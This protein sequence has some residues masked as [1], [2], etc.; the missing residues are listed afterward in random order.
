MTKNNILKILVTLPTIYLTPSHAMMTDDYEAL[1]TK[2]PILRQSHKT[3]IFA[4]GHD[5]GQEASIQRNGEGTSS[6]NA[7]D[8]VKKRES[9]KQEGE[10]MEQNKRLS[11]SA[12]ALQESLRKQGLTDCRVVEFSES[13][14]TALDAAAVIGCDVAQIVKVFPL[15]L[16]Q[17]ILYHRLL[18]LFFL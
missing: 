9:Q 11:K 15:S 10:E 18:I 8:V 4:N 14:R 6:I 5:E 3:S 17:L 1:E 12:Q 7:L 2:A 16:N 13:T